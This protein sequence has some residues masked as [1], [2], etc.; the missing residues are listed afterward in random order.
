MMTDP[1]RQFEHSHAALTALASE[2]RDVVHTRAPSEAI[3]AQLGP[4]LTR[5]RDELL[6]HF[7]KEEEGLFPF[8]RAHVPTKES[9]V[10][11]LG[12]AHDAICGAIVRLAHLVAQHDKRGAAHAMLL[13][14]YGRFESAYAAHSREESELFEELG[15]ALN[16][17]QR[18]ELAE[19]LRGL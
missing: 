5:L 8:V 14:H 12:S 13:E 17:Q 9:I 2:I 16:T 7:A 15:R 18:A 10:D 4:Q 19:I 1:V 11:R 6:V 3:L